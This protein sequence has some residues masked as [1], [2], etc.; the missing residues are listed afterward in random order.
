MPQISEQPQMDCPKINNLIDSIEGTVHEVKVIFQDVKIT[1]K[2]VINQL[3]NCKFNS[4]MQI[5]LINDMMDL[6]KVE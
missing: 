3:E 5:N 6:A 1:V 2:E 4:R